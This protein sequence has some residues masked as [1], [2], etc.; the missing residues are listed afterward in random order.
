MWMFIGLLVTFITGIYTSTNVDAL[1]VIFNKSGYWIL[2]I[3]EL[4]L[5]IFLSARIHKMSP[6]TAR[7]CYLLYTFFTGLT[8]SSI[9]IVYKIESIM[10][11]F[12]VTAIL[13]LIFAIIGK[14]TKVDLTKIST[15]LLMA[16]LGVIICTIINIFLQNSTFDMILSGISVLIFLGF[17]A[18][19]IQ[20]IKRLDGWVNE[21]NLAVIGAFELYLDFINIFLDLLNLFGNSKD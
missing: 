11:V 4:G 9:F 19:D 16:L 6:T 18:Y 15:I 14:T 1:E 7:I 5:A 21:E 2:L 12:L 17:I 3:V 13:F 10:L 20:K 8:F